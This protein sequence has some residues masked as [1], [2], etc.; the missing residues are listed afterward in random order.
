MYTSKVMKNGNSNVVVIP[1]QIMRSLKLRR[2]D[3]L[4]AEVDGDCLKFHTLRA[5]AIA[6]VRRDEAANAR[7]AATAGKSA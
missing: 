1:S 7:N 6:E 2:G 4:V 5:H 3:L